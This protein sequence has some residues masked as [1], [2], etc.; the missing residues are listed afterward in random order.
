MGTKHVVVVFAI[1]VTFKRDE[2]FV[3]LEEFE[4]ETAVKLEA[5]ARP[6]ERPDQGDSAKSIKGSSGGGKE[7]VG[8]DGGWSRLIF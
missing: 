1:P 6:T 5:I 3:T 4:A 7:R 2:V 8:K